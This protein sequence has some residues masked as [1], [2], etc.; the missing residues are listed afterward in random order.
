M[1]RE[2]KGISTFHDYYEVHL[3]QSEKI[4]IIDSGNGR[5]STEHFLTIVLGETS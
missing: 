5:S 2:R 1:T 4:L 3:S